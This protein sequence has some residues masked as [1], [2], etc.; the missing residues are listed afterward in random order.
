MR[1]T[2]ELI[3]LADM[4]NQLPIER[5]DDLF[6]KIEESPTVQF[7]FDFPYVE[8]FLTA[9]RMTPS[10]GDIQIMVE[11]Y[12]QGFVSGEQEHWFE[13]ENGDDDSTAMTWQV[14]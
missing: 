3:T 9:D 11:L 4:V 14:V 6:D 13:D 12:V 8:D 5:H 1:F 2:T 10:D 7:A